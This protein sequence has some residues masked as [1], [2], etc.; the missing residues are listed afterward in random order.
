MR[1]R[2]KMLVVMFVGR[3]KPSVRRIVLFTF[4]DGSAVSAVQRIGFEDPVGTV[5]AARATCRPERY[6]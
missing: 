5:D 3:N 4:G 6:L 2:F 1:Q